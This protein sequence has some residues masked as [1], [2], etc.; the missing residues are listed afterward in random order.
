MHVTFAGSVASLKYSLKYAAPEVVYALEAG[1]IAIIVD[2]AVD[3]WAIGVVAFEL[4][5][6][7]RAFPNC[8]LSFADSN[9]AA[10]DAISGRM[11]LPWERS[12]DITMAQLEK[13]RVLRPTVLQCLARDPTQRPTADSLVGLWDRTFDLMQTQPY[14]LR[15]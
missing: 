15:T 2:A 7:E 8:G 4:L 11:L 3:I 6:G 13:L 5:T 14:T 9:Q 10:R 12:D 1:D